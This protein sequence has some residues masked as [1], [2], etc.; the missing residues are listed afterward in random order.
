MAR[1]GKLKKLNVN[2]LKDRLSSESSILS[3]L[4]TSTL[5]S[6]FH[7]T[8]DEETIKSPTFIILSLSFVVF[9]LF[10]VIDVFLFFS[11]LSLEASYKERLLAIKPYQ[12]KISILT[13]EVSL[14]RTKYN[15]LNNRISS[16]KYINNIFDNYHNQYA[17]LSS[18]VSFVLFNF[19]NQGIYPSSV[20]INTNPISLNPST[21]NVSIDTE[22]FQ[23]KS[24]VANLKYM[25]GCYDVNIPKL[26]INSIQ[27]QD[28]LKVNKFGFAYFEKHFNLTASFVSKGGHHENLKKTN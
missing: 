8:L 15:E 23:N 20:S 7:I 10:I 13:K 22:S 9:L 17:A 1:Q 4:P 5:L 27:E 24:P 3:K 19:T 26:C 2:L 12:N 28:T 18:F 16:F 25:N 14:L 6:L 11:N 21:V